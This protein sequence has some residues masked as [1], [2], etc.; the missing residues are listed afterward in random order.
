MQLYDMK[1][2]AS[3]VSAE[4]CNIKKK[5][6]SWLSLDCIEIRYVLFC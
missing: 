3:V 2:S 1:T 5:Q 4:D 6:E